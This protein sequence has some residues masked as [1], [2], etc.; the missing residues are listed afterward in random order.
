M[1]V[2]VQDGHCCLPHKGTNFLANHNRNVVKKQ[3][4]AI[5]VYPTKVLI[6]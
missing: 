6:F 5:V 2:Q 3:N 1:Y 4:G